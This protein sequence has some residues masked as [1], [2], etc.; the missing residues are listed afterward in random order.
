MCTKE[1]TREIVKSENPLWIKVLV[2]LILALVTALS[3]TN[4]SVS[5]AS[6][7]YQKQ[8]REEQAKS[9]IHLSNQLLVFTTEIK[10]NFDLLKYQLDTIDKT[11]KEKCAELNIR[12]DKVERSI[13]KRHDE[14][15]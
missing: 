11:S 12:I 14:A 5:S 3:G 7:Q 8:T 2:G 15:P 10:G 9:I 1:E 4:L 13:R 6:E